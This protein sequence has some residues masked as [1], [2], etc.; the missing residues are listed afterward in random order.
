MLIELPTRFA[1]KTRCSQSCKKKIRNEMRNIISRISLICEVG[2]GGGWKRG[3]GLG[4][5]FQIS[6]GGENAAILFPQNSFYTLIFS[7][8]T[9]V[10][11]CSHRKMSKV[12]RI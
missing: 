3:S 8:S 4:Q 7:I 6:N 1:V 5:Y 2:G 9:P 11:I 10:R 12:A